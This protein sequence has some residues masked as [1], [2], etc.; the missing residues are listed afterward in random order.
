MIPRESDPNRLPSPITPGTEP[1]GCTEEMLTG[2]D[3][4]VYL[5]LRGFADSLNLSVAAAL[6]TLQL[7][8]MDPSLGC[9]MSEA[10][11]HELRKD[12]CE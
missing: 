8:H 12:W 6:C 1:V 3:R 11:K 9:D 2:A 4:R 7:F 5:P 10:E